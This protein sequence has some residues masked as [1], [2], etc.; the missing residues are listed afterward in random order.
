MAENAFTLFPNLPSELRLL[1]WDSTLVP[2]VFRVGIGVNAKTAVADWSPDGNPVALRVCAESRAVALQRLTVSLPIYQYHEESALRFAKRYL[3]PDVDVVAVDCRFG[4]EGDRAWGSANADFR[5][6]MSALKAVEP[7]GGGSATRTKACVRRIA[8]PRRWWLSR[9][10]RPDFGRTS[11]L[12]F[13]E[14]RQIFIL[15]DPGSV[16][17]SQEEAG[18]TDVTGNGESEPLLPPRAREQHIA[19]GWK[20]ESREDGLEVTQPGS[21][22]STRIR[23]RGPQLDWIMESCAQLPK[24]PPGDSFFKIPPDVAYG[25][26]P[27]CMP[28]FTPQRNLGV[29]VIQPRRSGLRAG[30]PTVSEGN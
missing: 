29:P 26:G 30:P 2:R 13:R 10:S 22:V 21:E 15:P 1:I 28:G 19:S 5:A 17:E 16:S 23:D 9:W 12:L 24:P 6:L 4:S 27:D 20:I 8:L 14:L 18:S 11:R 3:D 7:V 25:T